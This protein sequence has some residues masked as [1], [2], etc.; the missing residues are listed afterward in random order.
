MSRKKDSKQIKKLYWGNIFLLLGIIVFVLS[1]TV[2]VSLVLMKLALG[3]LAIYFIYT[4][5]YGGIVLNKYPKIGFLSVELNG[6][7]AQLVGILYILVGLFASIII[8]FF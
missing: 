3:L 5:Y 4:G 8:F 1:L 6:I 2:G 7:S